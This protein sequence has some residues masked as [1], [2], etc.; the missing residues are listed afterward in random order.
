M[1]NREDGLPADQMERAKSVA[2]LIMETTTPLPVNNIYVNGE[3]IDVNGYSVDSPEYWGG[4]MH[5]L[6]NT[7]ESSAA[8]RS[9]ARAM[10]NPDSFG[11]C[12]Q[13][14]ICKFWASFIDTFPPNSPTGAFANNPAKFHELGLKYFMHDY[15]TMMVYIR[16]MGLVGMRFSRKYNTPEAIASLLRSMTGFYTDGPGKDMKKAVADAYNAADGYDSVI[17]VVKPFFDMAHAN[18]PY[19]SLAQLH[20]GTEYRVIMKYYYA[21]RDYPEVLYWGRRLNYALGIRYGEEWIGTEPDRVVVSA[22]N[23]ILGRIMQPQNKPPVIALRRVGLNPQN[24]L[25][26]EQTAKLVMWY[27]HAMIETQ[28]NPESSWKSQLENDFQEFSELLTSVRWHPRVFFWKMVLYNTMGWTFQDTDSPE[29][30]AM[31]FDLLVYIL[32]R[33]QNAANLQYFKDCIQFD[34][35]PNQ[36]A[37]HLDILNDLFTMV[38]NL[39]PSGIFRPGYGLAQ[40]SN[41]Q[42]TV[43]SLAHREKPVVQAAINRYRAVL[44]C[45]EAE[46][47]SETLTAYIASMQERYNKFTSSL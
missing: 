22:I 13:D 37:T 30:A 26:N 39:N 31:H 1:A 7:Y 45:P 9:L 20:A 15:E 6:G 47:V 42:L 21:F 25:P 23:Q 3:S 38:R 34:T 16:F 18:L 43:Q 5:S 28:L 12:S 40:I 17:A 10:L 36:T 32:T 19:S 44:G 14:N 27:L 41:W 29:W 35:S 4:L 2:K 46:D 11:F 8:N 24:T 33:P